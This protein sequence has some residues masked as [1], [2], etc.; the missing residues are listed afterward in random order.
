MKIRKVIIPVAGL[1]TRLLPTTKALPKEMLPVG[2]IPVIQHVVEEMATAGMSKLLFVTSRSKTIIENQFDN[3]SAI[4]RHL[5]ESGRLKALGDFDYQKRGI[6][7]FY[8]RQQTAVGSL[9]PGGTGEAI[10]AGESFIGDDPFVVAFGDTIIRSEAEPT[11][12]QRLVAAHAEQGAT[13]TIGVRPVPEDKTSLYGIVQPDIS[14]VL[15][16]RPFR[17]SDII[18]KPPLGKAPTNLAVSARYVFSPGIFEEIRS[19]ESGGD[20]ELGITAAIRS[21]IEKGKPVVCVPLNENETRYDIGGHQSYY[22]AFIDYALADPACG[23]AIRE[24]IRKLGETSE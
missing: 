12:L 10:L 8:S 13:I 16:G 7:F 22:K 19:P 9:K 3:N 18:E 5:D 23:E 14:E 2:R 17:I 1:G 11:F 24:Y 6:E 20:A 15:D 4:V 21:T